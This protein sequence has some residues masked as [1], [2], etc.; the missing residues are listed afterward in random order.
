LK[1]GNGKSLFAASSPSEGVLL[2]NDLDD[3]FVTKT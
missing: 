3:K 2:W 1:F